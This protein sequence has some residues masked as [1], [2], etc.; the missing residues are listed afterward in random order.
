MDLGLLSNEQVS[1]IGSINLL[2]VPF[3]SLASGLLMDPLGKRRMMQVSTPCFGVFDVVNQLNNVNIPI[4]AAEFANAGR[5]DV[6]LF[7]NQYYSHLHC[8]CAIWN[9]WRTSRS[10]GA[11]VNKVIET[12][13]GV[14]K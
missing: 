13:L 5:L 4:V 8:S 9:E 12:Y 14:R 6:I 10:A 1:W 3:G 7:W 11:C 2:F